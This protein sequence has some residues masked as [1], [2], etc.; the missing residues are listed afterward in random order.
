MGAIDWVILTL[1]AVAVFLGWRRGLAAAV[2][3]LM[4]VIAGFFLVGHFYPLV[5]RSLMIK[6]KLSSS[7]STLLA[8]LLISVLLA[9]VVRLVIAALN[10]VLKALKLSSLNRFAGMLLGFA[11]GLLILICV[12]IVLD[13]FPRVSTPLK[14]SSRHRVYAGVNLLKDELLKGLNLKQHLKHLELKAKNLKLPDF[15]SDKD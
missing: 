14:D 12:M 6:Y 3:N 1:L 5:A 2:I 11:N 4:G 8:V 10:R 9:V 7:L 15:K 13:Y